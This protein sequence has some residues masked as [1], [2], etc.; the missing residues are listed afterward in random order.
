MD[1]ARW[2]GLASPQVANPANQVLHV[3]Q[4]Q[5]F[6]ALVPALGEGGTS[7]MSF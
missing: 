5:N 6:T 1:W 7:K 2:T 4:G 3:F